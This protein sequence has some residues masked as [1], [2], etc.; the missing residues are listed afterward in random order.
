M[1]GL[2]RSEFVYCCDP[3]KL[4]AFYKPAKAPLAGEGYY[5]QHSSKEHGLD[6][7]RG[8]DGILLGKRGP[9]VYQLKRHVEEV[10]P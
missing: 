7:C 1:L 4:S 2:Q 8:M 10:I 6:N 5:N 9:E 3:L